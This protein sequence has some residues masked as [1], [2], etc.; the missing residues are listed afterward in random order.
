[1][2]DAVATRAVHISGSL[3][4]QEVSNVLWACAV[5]RCRCAAALCTRRRDSEMIRFR[6]RPLYLKLA[7]RAEEIKSDLHPQAVGNIAWVCGAAE[8]VRPF[9][10]LVS[11]I[12]QDVCGRRQ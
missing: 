11:G 10:D 12:E 3:R 2:V 1:M 5:L 7:A 4:G 6:L 8:A 9:A